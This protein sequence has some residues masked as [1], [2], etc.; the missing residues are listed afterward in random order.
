MKNGFA[1]LIVIMILVLMGTEMFVLTG[2]SNKIAF[3]TNHALLEAVQQNLISSGLT[4]A[5]Y[6]IE[7]KNIKETKEE[8]RLDTAEIGIREA[9]LGATTE[10]IQNK[11]A[12]VVINAFCSRGRESL[13]HNEKYQ[14]ALRRR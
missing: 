14:I 8:I 13:K 4:W 5:K 7:N 3:Q 11:Q 2:S 12:Q 9:Q 1:L 6:N 10:K